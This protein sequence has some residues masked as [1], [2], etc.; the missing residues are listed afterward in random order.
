M[1]AP[2]IVADIGGT[3]GRFAIATPSN[4][5]HQFSEIR[6]LDSP[7]YPSLVAI[8][9]AYME[10]LED[11]V[12][13]RACVA[14]AGPVTGNYVKGTNLGWYVDI[15]ADRRAL[16][17]SQLKVIN[18]FQAAALGLTQLKKGERRIIK[19]GNPLP[20]APIAVLGPGTGLG[21]ACLMPDSNG[22]QAVACE[23]G[24]A[25]LAANTELQLQILTQLKSTNPNDHLCAETLLCGSGIPLLYQSYC[26]I[27]KL[28]HSQLSAAEINVKAHNGDPAALACLT[29]FCEWL[30]SFASDI[31]LAQGA[32]GGVWLAGG[33]LPKI[34]SILHR[35]QFNH[36]F[37]NKGAVKELLWETPITLALNTDVAL[38]GAA[39]HMMR[40]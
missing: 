21:V 6:Y 15:E 5:G 31:A 38:Q 14:I 34:E 37:V 2:F 1:N 39:Y 13:F 28:P 23:G 8:L 17:L 30:G 16:G 4:G 22:Y 10:F 33:V 29:L 32:R 36:A 3:N 19:K 35:S 9:K 20:D 7:S 12:P 26:A 18:D 25:T 11:N 40:S 27:K 24:H